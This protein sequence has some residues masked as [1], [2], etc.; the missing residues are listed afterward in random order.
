[1]SEKRKLYRGLGGRIE[2]L[3]LL[4]DCG[5][6]LHTCVSVNLKGHDVMRDLLFLLWRLEKSGSR[7]Y[8]V[9]CVYEK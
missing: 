2:M 4:E 8:N 6:P 3:G 9:G 7:A 5:V 1:M